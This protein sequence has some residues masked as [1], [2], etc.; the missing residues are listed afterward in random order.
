MDHPR[1]SSF[2]LVCGS[3]CET[4]S[5]TGI[6]TML[7]MDGVA[8]SILL[9]IVHGMFAKGTIRSFLMRKILTSGQRNTHI[10]L[11]PQCV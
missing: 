4:K 9:S 10:C 8:S 11:H 7:N 6:C 1:D 3:V 5:W 2:V